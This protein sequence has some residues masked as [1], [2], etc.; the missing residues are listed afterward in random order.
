MIVTM[1]QNSH[2]NVNTAESATKTEGGRWSD[3]LKSSSSSKS[4]EEA[5][6]E[7]THIVNKHNSN[8]PIEIR[9]RNGD[10]Q[11]ELEDNSIIIIL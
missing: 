10:N 11:T 4:L 3:L 2:V 6:M 1:T 5:H 9:K 7:V 8:N